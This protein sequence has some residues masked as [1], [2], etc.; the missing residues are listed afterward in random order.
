MVFCSY[1]LTRR[2]LTLWLATRESTDDEFGS[3]E[4][5]REINERFT[6]LG[7]AVISPDGRS[8]YFSAGTSASDLDPYVAT[9]SLRDDAHGGRMPFGEPVRLDAFRTEAT[10]SEIVWTADGRTAVFYRYPFDLEG[11]RDL[12][13]AWRD[14]A[15]DTL[16]IRS[17]DELNLALYDEATPSISQDGRTLLFGQVTFP[18]RPPAVDGEI[19]LARRERRFDEDGK[20]VRFGPALP[21]ADPEI[22]TGWHEMTPFLTSDWPR[23]GAQLYFAR[24]T[25]HSFANL[26]VATWR[27][28]RP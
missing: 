7:H 14:P 5:I 12:F 10:E 27:A 18:V 9:R 8:L 20:P 1:R 3:P 24:A 28:G 15:T 21:L 2:G 17:I 23:N 16:E 26:W 19:W 11:Q 4:P 22:N 6:K 13:E 25:E